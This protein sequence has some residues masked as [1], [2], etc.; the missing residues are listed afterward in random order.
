MPEQ[1]VDESLE[2]A[3][4]SRRTCDRHE[5]QGAVASPTFM[6]LA[7]LTARTPTGLL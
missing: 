2:S 5:G 4:T 1:R 6:P 7:C 3:V